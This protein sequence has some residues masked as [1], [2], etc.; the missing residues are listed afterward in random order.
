MV[1]AVVERRQQLQTGGDG[2]GTEAAPV[3]G[4]LATVVSPSGTWPKGC[5]A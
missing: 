2:E 1:V 4:A 5:V 3:A